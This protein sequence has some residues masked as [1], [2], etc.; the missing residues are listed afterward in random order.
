MR[1][2]RLEIENAHVFDQTSKALQMPDAPLVLGPQALSQNIVHAFY[3]R[4]YIYIFIY[5]YIYVY[6]RSA[7]GVTSD[8]VTL[9][10]G[11]G[12]QVVDIQVCL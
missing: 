1:H 7:A 5:I 11:R 12:R 8:I 3:T 9:P 4:M 2:K 6:I 10:A